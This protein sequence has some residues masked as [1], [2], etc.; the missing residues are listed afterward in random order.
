MSHYFN[1]LDHN[2]HAI[3]HMTA[4]NI[5]AQMDTAEQRLIGCNVPPSRRD[6]AIAFWTAPILPEEGQGHAV[7]VTIRRFPDAPEDMIAGENWRVVSIQGKIGFGDPHGDRVVIA[8]PFTDLKA[9]RAG[10][11]NC[12]GFIPY[13]EVIR[14]DAH[15]EKYRHNGCHRDISEIIG[16]NELIDVW[17]PDGPLEIEDLLAA[18]RARDA[19]VD[20]PPEPVRAF[21]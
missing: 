18:Q 3:R 14:Y 19:W 11:F 17:E 20:W 21:G 12:E 2:H 16:I 6:G 9:M 5:S 7:V 13:E 15:G 1:G 10:G 4:A 8:L